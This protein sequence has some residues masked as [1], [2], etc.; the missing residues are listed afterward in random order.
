MIADTLSRLPRGAKIGAVLLVLPFALASPFL[1]YAGLAVMNG[2]AD[3]AAPVG[4]LGAVL[5][6][7]VSLLVYLAVV[8]GLPLALGGLIGAGVQR[9]VQ[10]GQGGGA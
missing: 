3:W 7:L 8:F 4:R 9:M 1:V 6:G 2:M 5:V 10:K